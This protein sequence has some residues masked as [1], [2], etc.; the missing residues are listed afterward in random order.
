MKTRL[1]LI[2]TICSVLSGCYKEDVSVLYSH[3]HRLEKELEDLKDKIGDINQDITNLYEII[4]AM[5]L[6]DCVIKV[7]DLPDGSGYKLI[8]RYSGEKIIYHG[9]T[10]QI[11]YN[12]NW[13]IGGQDTGISAKGENGDDGNTPEIGNNGNWWIDGSDTGIPAKGQNGNTPLVSAAHDLLNP[14]DNNYYWTSQIGNNP[15][16]FILDANGQK[17]QA[18]GTNGTTPEVGIKQHADGEYYWTIKTNGNEAEWLLDENGNMVRA[19][20]LDGEK[21]DQGEPGQPGT[22][23][24]FESVDYTSSDD[25]VTF[26]LNDGNQTSFQVAKYKELW[27]TL[28]DTPN[29]TQS[30][31]TEVIRFTTHKEVVTVHTIIPDGWRAVVKLDETATGNQKTGTITLT[32]PELLNMYA[33][34]EGIVSVLAFNNKNMSVTASMP[35]W[36]GHSV[37][38]TRKERQY[39]TGYYSTYPTIGDYVGFTSDNTR[40]KQGLPYGMRLYYF[41]DLS[42]ATGYSTLDFEDVPG[43]DLIDKKPY[44]I[45]RSAADELTVI[46]WGNEPNVTWDDYNQ[47]N[48]PYDLY[49]IEASLKEHP[50]RSGCYQPLAL[51]NCNIWWQKWAFK[52]SE[53]YNEPYEVQCW[54]ASADVQITIYNA[55]TALFNGHPVDDPEQLWVSLDNQGR[56][57]EFEEAEISKKQRDNKPLKVSIAPEV[58]YETG[59]FALNGNNT[60]NKLTAKRFGTFGNYGKGN[61]TSI[62]LWNGSQKLKT[63]SLDNSA[64]TR[65]NMGDVRHF[66]IF[67]AN[68]MYIISIGVNS[69][70]IWEQGVDL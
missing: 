3:Q 55:G 57:C 15:A 30:S 20:G 6:D 27:I 40:E 11:G 66:E 9:N 32:S 61:S 70:T 39:N 65:I 33:Q 54:M 19:T 52:N 29:F 2:I 1:L 8:F 45:K 16:E 34:A 28:T 7:E 58:T 42:S 24:L 53:I 12:N 62:T 25:Y 41:K 22:K 5:E 38:F 48:A 37:F 44:K 49:D 69:W 18:N 26:V 17:I 50:T 60:T 13:W 68:S 23:C 43:N 56:A 36:V 10:P 46:A 63:F 67:I 64:Y 51:D 4:N 31:Q 59:N 47:P 21:G 14:S 35:V